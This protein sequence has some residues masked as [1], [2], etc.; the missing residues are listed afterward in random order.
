MGCALPGPLRAAVSLVNL[1]SWGTNFAQLPQT[2]S[3]CPP[4]SGP[5]PVLSF[6][7]P[8]SSQESGSLF[9]RSYPEELKLEGEFKAALALF[10]VAVGLLVCRLELGEEGLLW[11]PG[12]QEDVTVKKKK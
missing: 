2:V 3:S 1:I 11:C 4:C 10:C 12:E 9:I 6:P 7:R 5:A 8:P